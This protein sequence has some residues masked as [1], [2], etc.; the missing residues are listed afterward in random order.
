[1]TKK[2]NFLNRNSSIFKD[3]LER[4]KD[5]LS[6]L[7]GGS[8]ILVIGAAGTIGQSVFY[9]LFSRKPKSI[10]AV[11]ISE[12]NLVELVRTI[13]SSPLDQSPELKTYAIDY[14]SNEFK[15]LIESTDNFDYVFNLSA[16]KHVRSEKDEFTLM[17]LIRVNIF[18][19]MEILKLLSPTH[20]K[21]YFV[22]CSVKDTNKVIMM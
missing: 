22:V 6:H 5:D 18:N 2:N 15:F 13:R 11:D 7:I 9:E 10:H 1:M 21:K 8:R 20:L 14:G 12:N 19:T 16:L 4:I 3:D 17:R